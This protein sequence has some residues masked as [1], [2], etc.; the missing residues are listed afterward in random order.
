IVMSIGGGENSPTVNPA[1][2]QLFVEP[3]QGPIAQNPAGSD[4]LL[5]SFDI[6]NF[7]PGDNPTGAVYLDSVTVDN[8]PTRALQD[9]WVTE[10]TY[11]FDNGPQGWQPGG[12]PGVF[13][14]PEFS[15]RNGALFLKAKNNTNTFGYWF[16]PPLPAEASKLYRAQLFISTDQ[17]SRLLT[18]TFRLR[19]NDV[20]GQLAGTYCV[21]SLDD[22]D[23]SPNR[24]ESLEYH[25]YLA[26]RPHIPAQVASVDI[27]NLDPNDAVTGEIIVYHFSLESCSLSVFP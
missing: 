6:L 12:A 19:L 23:A 2:Y 27:I 7:D 14:L 3:I 16:S 25:V 1:V 22:A 9:K 4:W 5:I 15:A 18:P 13:D 24:N 11:S 17:S 20:N 21:Y 8:F 10:A 26:M